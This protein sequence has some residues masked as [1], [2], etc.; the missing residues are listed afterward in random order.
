MKGVTVY[1]PP[2]AA[3]RAAL[4]AFNVE[5][6]HA[7]DISTVL[8]SAGE[9]FDKHTGFLQDQ[10]AT[11]NDMALSKCCVNMAVLVIRFTACRGTERVWIGDE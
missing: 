3:G 4:C 5:G 8:D 2:P 1:G 10:M 11:F 7:S 9:A 6:L